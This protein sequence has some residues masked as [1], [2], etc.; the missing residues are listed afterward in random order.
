MTNTVECPTFGRLDL[1]LQNKALCLSACRIRS[2][3]PPVIPSILWNLVKPVETI[4]PCQKAVVIEL[5]SVKKNE[6]IGILMLIVLWM[7]SLYEHVRRF[8]FDEA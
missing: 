6:D 7:P 1:L 4:I 3:D 8:V 5:K 2:A